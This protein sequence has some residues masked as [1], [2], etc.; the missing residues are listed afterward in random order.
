MV[1][2]RKVAAPDAPQSH[3]VEALLVEREA[4]GRMAHTDNVH[5]SELLEV[6]RLGED[7]E[8]GRAEEDRLRV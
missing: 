4:L 1:S 3:T 2:W 5:L 6:G 7:A 8:S